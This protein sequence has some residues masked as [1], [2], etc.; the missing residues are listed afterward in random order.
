MQEKKSIDERLAHLDRPYGELIEGISPQRA[1]IARRLKWV[2]LF[3]IL[4][5]LTWY[6]GQP[7]NNPFTQNTRALYTYYRDSLLIIGLQKGNGPVTAFILGS[8]SGADTYAIPFEAWN[9]LTLRSSSATA[10]RHFAPPP[11]LT[12]STNVTNKNKKSLSEYT[13][14]PLGIGRPVSSCSTYFDIAAVGMRVLVLR[15]DSGCVDSIVRTDALAKKYDLVISMHLP[16]SVNRRIRDILRPYYL[17]YAVP[18]SPET[19]DTRHNIL[20]FDPA[21]SGYRFT[22]NTDGTIA[23]QPVSFPRYDSGEQ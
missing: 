10:H 13:K 20:T 4:G 5:L 22:R 16:H 23:A 19:T 17:V 11:Q 9:L 6:A 14:T 8:G 2:L 15:N 18:V 21:G 12:I 1:R 7:H 3:T